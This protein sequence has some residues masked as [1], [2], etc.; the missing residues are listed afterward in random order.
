MCLFKPRTNGKE[1]VIFWFMM[2]F[3]D[4][5]WKASL[6]IS[7]LHASNSLSSLLPTPAKITMK[8]IIPERWFW[9]SKSL[10][11]WV[12]NLAS[13]VCGW[14]KTT[15]GAKSL[16]TWRTATLDLGG[17]FFSLDLMEKEIRVRENAGR[18]LAVSWG[19]SHVIATIIVYEMGWELAVFLSFLDPLPQHMEVPRLGVKSEV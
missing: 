7:F 5:S 8:R 3:C 19:C 2:T 15:D 16:K 4:T 18:Y 6:K 14:K 13:K 9:I 12:I 11:C 10:S 1:G 17:K